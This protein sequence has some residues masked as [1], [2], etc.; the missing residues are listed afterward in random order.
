MYLPH[1]RIVVDCYHPKGVLTPHRRVVICFQDF[2]VE[3]TMERAALRQTQQCGPWE[4]KERLGTGGFGHVNL[5]QH[6]VSRATF[7]LWNLGGALLRCSM[8]LTN[9]TTTF[10]F[11]LVKKSFMNC[12]SYT[13]GCIL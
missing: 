10:F 7:N 4:M 3:N 13:F 6:L 2:Q 11:L 5:Y 1:A 9:L 12:C 8:A